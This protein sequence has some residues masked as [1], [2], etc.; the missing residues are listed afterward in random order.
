[1]TLYLIVALLFLITVTQI[2]KLV[3]LFRTEQKKENQPK[4]LPEVDSLTDDIIKYSIEKD[5]LVCIMPGMDNHLTLYAKNTETGD[6]VAV[7]KVISTTAGK[8]SKEYDKVL[9][10]MKDNID[11]YLE[12]KEKYVKN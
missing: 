12:N 1:M 5:M 8:G 2:I 6:N 11:A 9:Q 7:C 10:E 3:Y 4:I